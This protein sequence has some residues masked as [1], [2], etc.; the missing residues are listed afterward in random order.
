[1][2]LETVI[3]EKEDHIAKVSLNRP[4]RLKRHQPADV[5]GA[6]PGFDGTWQR[7]PRCGFWCSPA[8]VGPSALPPTS[9]KSVRVATAC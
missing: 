9:K 2:D 7:T 4:E 8:R 5:R 3:L 6:E 1:M